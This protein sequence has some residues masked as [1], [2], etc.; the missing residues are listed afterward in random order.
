MDMLLHIF[1]LLIKV[2]PIKKKIKGVELKTKGYYVPLPPLP[3]PPLYEIRGRKRAY[4][5]GYPEG[6]TL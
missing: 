1:R 6:I 3:P 5:K 2:A 4:N